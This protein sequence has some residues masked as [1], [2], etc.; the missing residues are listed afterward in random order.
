MT[1]PLSNL[2]IYYSY[3]SQNNRMVMRLLQLE[4]LELAMIQ[5]LPIS[6]FSSCT[7]YAISLSIS[8]HQR[9]VEAV[10]APTQDEHAWLELEY[11][12]D[13]GRLVQLA[14][15]HRS[16]CASQSTV[17]MCKSN[18]L[19]YTRIRK[20]YLVVRQLSELLAKSEVEW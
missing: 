4:S 3:K 9:H 1:R 13:V 18:Q 14:A 8:R 6:I 2:A 10:S 12:H 19:K 5:C 11:M 7:S 15:R 16:P 17:H 20:S